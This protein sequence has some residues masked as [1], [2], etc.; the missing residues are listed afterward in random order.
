MTVFLC[1]RNGCVKGEQHCSLK[2]KLHLLPRP[3]RQL[4]TNNM[5]KLLS[6]Q[7]TI[8]TVIVIGVSI[9]LASCEE[10]AVKLNSAQIQAITKSSVVTAHQI[11]V[12][13]QEVLDITS[14][15]L[16]D[17]G[18]AIEGTNASPEN[19]PPWLD[20]QYI[21]DLTHYDTIIYAG[22]ITLNYGNGTECT[23]K[24]T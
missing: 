18:I 1:S 9:G 5:K 6:H 10:E 13:A 22:T 24:N 17:E 15:V 11:F 2:I 14:D 19:C 23:D 21:M 12:T 16:S 8:F 20:R 4:N 3:S 7:F